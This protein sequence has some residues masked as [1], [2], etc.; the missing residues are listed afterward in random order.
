MLESIGGWGSTYKCVLDGGDV[1]I[2]RRVRSTYKR[3][4]DGGDVGIDRRVGS[5][6]KLVL[7]VAYVGIDGGQLINTSLK[8]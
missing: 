7:E 1:E 5:T 3:V 4:L 8:S 6:Y 2:A